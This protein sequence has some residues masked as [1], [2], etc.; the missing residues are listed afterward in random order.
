[1]P[2]DPN[3]NVVAWKLE[4]QSF[5]ETIGNDDLSDE[6]TLLALAKLIDQHEEAFSKNGN[7]FANDL[8]EVAEANYDADDI[9][10]EGNYVLERIYN[11]ADRHLIWLGI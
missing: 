7:S 2:Y 10:N 5:R 6:E 9:E 8:R 11:Y 1:M 3:G 4:I